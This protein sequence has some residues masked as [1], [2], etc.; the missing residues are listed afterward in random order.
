LKQ[1]TNTLRSATNTLRSK[2]AAFQICWG[3]LFGT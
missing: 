3:G 2:L 1:T